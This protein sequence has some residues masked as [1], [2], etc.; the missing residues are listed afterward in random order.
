MWWNLDMPASRVFALANLLLEVLV[1][2][3][4]TDLP[5]LRTLLLRN[6]FMVRLMDITALTPV[7][8]LAH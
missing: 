7:C 6:N 4:T 2:D 8:Y 3:R 5:C 1:A